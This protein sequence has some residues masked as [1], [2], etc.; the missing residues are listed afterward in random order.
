MTYLTSKL[1]MD[2]KVVYGLLALL[3]KTILIDKGK[4]LA[5]KII[6]CKNFT[7]NYRPSEESNRRRSLH[8]P[9]TLPRIKGRLTNL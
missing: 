7:Q 1:T 9:D 6:N 2:E 8:L 3:A 5:P 4:T